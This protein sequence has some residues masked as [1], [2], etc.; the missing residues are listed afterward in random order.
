MLAGSLPAV[1]RHGVLQQISPACAYDKCLR[2]ACLCSTGAHQ[3]GK[4]ADHGCTLDHP[5]LEAASMVT[6]HPAEHRS[7][8]PASSP[9]A[10]ACEITLLYSGS[11]QQG[12][13]GPNITAASGDEGQSCISDALQDAIMITCD[14]HACKLMPASCRAELCALCR[15]VFEAVLIAYIATTAA[16]ATD[17]N[18]PGCGPTGFSPI[19][20]TVPPCKCAS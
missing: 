7:K 17:T 11:G 13:I 20:K 16:G 2:Y 6:Y 9:P 3:A 10:S 1:S 18:A 14:V 4:P 8:V 19:P 5:P 12:T 15:I